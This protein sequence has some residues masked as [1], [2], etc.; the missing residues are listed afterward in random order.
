MHRRLLGRLATLHFAPTEGARQNL[1]REG[2]RPEA[3]LVT[4]NTIIDALRLSGTRSS[5]DGGP[6]AEGFGGG[7]SVLLVT[8][9]RRENEG[10]A[11]AVAEAANELA[12]RQ[13][14]EVIWVRHGNP[15]SAAAVRCL[16]PRVRVIDPLPYAAFIHLLSRARVVLT[17]SGGIQEEAPVL[18]VPVVVLRS[19][20]D[21]PEGVAA[22]NAVVAGLSRSD[23]VRTCAHV[24]D[25]PRAPARAE[26]PFGD[27]HAAPRILQAITR[28]LRP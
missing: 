27:G 12:E 15:T 16:G 24:L 5:P 19:E 13:D 20:T 2:V 21:R 8:L 10:N 4:G 7:P 6:S 28:H 18:G 17:D 1:E 25:A 23:I 14:V 9:H 3:I 22:G 26:S 11:G